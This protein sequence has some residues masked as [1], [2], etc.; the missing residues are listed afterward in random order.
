MVRDERDSAENF[1]PGQIKRE[2]DADCPRKNF[3]I[4]DVVGKT[5]RIERFD[6]AGVNENAADDKIDSA[7]CDRTPRE[8]HFLQK[9]P[10]P[11]PPLT[12]SAVA[13]A[14]RPTLNV[15]CRGSAFPIIRC[16]T[17]SVRCLLHFLVLSHSSQPPS[18]TKT[19][20]NC[21]SWRSRRATS[22]LALQLWLLQYTTTRF[23]GDHFS[24]N[25][26]SNSFQRSSFN[27]IAPRT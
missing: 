4:I 12:G 7:P 24:S 13:S 1:Q 11:S 17:F 23:S 20:F 26:G 25:S 8:I 3:V 19:F 27:K 18:S 14:Q 10:N 22:R 16:S 6:C 2:P 15:E 5:D 9:T 21:A